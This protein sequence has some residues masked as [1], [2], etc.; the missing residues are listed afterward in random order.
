VRGEPIVC[1]PA[2]AWRCFLRTQMDCL[3]LGPFL[4]DKAEQ[5]PLGENA[6]WSGSARGDRVWSGASAPDPRSEPQ[7]SEGRKGGP[8]WPGSATD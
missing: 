8:S 2:D 7:A 6:D 3:A 5:P 1:T 4:L